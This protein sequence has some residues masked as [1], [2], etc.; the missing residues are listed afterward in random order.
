MRRTW[1]LAAVLATMAMLFTGTLAGPAGADVTSGTSLDFVDITFKLGGKRTGRLTL[2]L[3]RG[4]KSYANGSLARAK[5]GRNKVRLFTDR[6]MPPGKY[7]LR[8]TFR[9]ANG[10]KSTSGRAIVTVKSTAKSSS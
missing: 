7:T 10:D 3:T 8:W 2:R 6:V 4:T 9:P 1:T 5:P